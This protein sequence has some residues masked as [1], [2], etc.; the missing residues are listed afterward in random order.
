MS[1]IPPLQ[2]LFCRRLNPADASFCNEC[3][4]QLNLQPCDRCGAIDNRSATNCYKCG[5]E[6]TVPPAPGPDALLAPEVLDKDATYPALKNTT[7][8]R[9]GATPANHELT[10]SLPAALPVLEAVSSETA[11]TRSGSR[12][13]G[14]VAKQVLLLALLGLLVYLYLEPSAPLAQKPGSAELVPVVS[15][16]PMSASSGA[17]T[18]TAPLDATLTPTDTMQTLAQAADE[19]AQPALPAPPG[20]R[21]AP[22]ARPL[23][24][25]DSDPKVRQNPAI[26]EECPSAIATLGLCNPPKPQ[27]IQ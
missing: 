21:A 13:S 12:R 7:V 17:A 4:S 27:E 19:P 9:L 6:F 18:K 23:P 25:P 1:W 26:F 10:Q 2:C 14:P 8:A 15:D 16:A 3:G 5:A 11:G 24:L 20:A 22:A